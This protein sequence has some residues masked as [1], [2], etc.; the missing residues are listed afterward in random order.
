MGE[1]TGARCNTMYRVGTVTGVV[2]DHTVEVDGMPQHVRD[3][4]SVVPVPERAPRDEVAS[5]DND[6]MLEAAERLSFP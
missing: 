6:V 5:N 2:S 3:L 1:A 4:R